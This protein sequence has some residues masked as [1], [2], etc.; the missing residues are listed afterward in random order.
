[1][2]LHVLATVRKRSPVRELLPKLVLQ[3]F[4]MGYAGLAQTILRYFQCVHE[5]PFY[6]LHSDPGIDCDSAGYKGVLVLFGFAFLLVPAPL[7]LL[8][9]LLKNHKLVVAVDKVFCERWGTLLAP[10]RVEAYWWGAYT[11]CRRTL[12]VILDVAIA[13]FGPKIVAMGLSNL[14]FVF[15][16][17]F[18][19]L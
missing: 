9:F 3:F 7:F 16:H 13:S 12:L 5:G 1:M 8:L 18:L 2:I 11:L 15:L 6:V 19:T 4:T 14:L 10:Y 17:H